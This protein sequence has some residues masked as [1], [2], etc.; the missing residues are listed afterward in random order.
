VPLPA[1]TATVEGCNSWGTGGSSA[2]CE[3]SV[4]HV[5]IDATAE[6]REAT[7]GCRLHLGATG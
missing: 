4:Q 1:V 7:K 2:R 5:R 3:R 6:Q